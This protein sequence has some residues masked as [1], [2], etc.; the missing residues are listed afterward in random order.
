M[1]SKGLT[2]SMTGSPAADSS[3]R[4]LQTPIRIFV[5]FT[6]LLRDAPMSPDTKASALNHLQDLANNY[7]SPEFFRQLDDFVSRLS[8]HRDLRPKLEPLVSALKTL[9]T[10]EPHLLVSERQVT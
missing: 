9:Q 8:Q 3:Q 5:D 4:R 7:R 10:Q 2:H 6:L 1:G